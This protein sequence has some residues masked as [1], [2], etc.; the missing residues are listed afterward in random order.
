VALLAFI[1]NEKLW[2]LQVGL[3]V[4]LLG[5][6]VFA[7]GIGRAKQS[8]WGSS[9]HQGA[10]SGSDTVSYSD[11]TYSGSF[12]KHHSGGQA[13]HGGHSHDGGDSGGG[14]DGGSGSD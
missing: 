10:G 4:L 14:G 8:N 6:L 3:Y 2:N 12:S 7:F 11:S 9:T 1:P 13:D 5:I